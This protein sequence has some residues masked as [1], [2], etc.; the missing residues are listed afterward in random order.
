MDDPP[1]SRSLRLFLT[2]L[3]AVLLFGEARP[4][5]EDVRSETV[6]SHVGART[7]NMR[8][9]AGRIFDDNTD[10]PTPDAP[11]TS[12]RDEPSR[13]ATVPVQRV[14]SHRPPLFMQGPFRPRAPPRDNRT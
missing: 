8:P 5:H 6:E 1:P 3:L 7:Q 11:V 13:T 4:L 12:V 10:V 9:G 14:D 2:A